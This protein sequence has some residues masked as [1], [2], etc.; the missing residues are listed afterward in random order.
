MTDGKRKR[1]PD[2]G[3]GAGPADH[4]AERLRLPN[5]RAPRPVPTG[6]RALEWLG[7]E[8][9][10]LEREASEATGTSGSPTQRDPR[11]HYSVVKDR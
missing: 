1:C 11:L 5:S 6:V 8:L 3:G 10:R 4:E 7:A 9:R 2:A